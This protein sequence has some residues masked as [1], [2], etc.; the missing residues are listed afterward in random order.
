MPTFFA[1]N[2]FGMCWLQDLRMIWGLDKVFRVQ[3]RT[4][5]MIDPEFP[6][7]D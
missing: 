4:A 2:S 7:L 3:N 1:F 6:C 5:L